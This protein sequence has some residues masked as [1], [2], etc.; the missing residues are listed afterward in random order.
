MEYVVSMQLRMITIQIN[1]YISF[2]TD[3]VDK[4]RTFDY[5]NQTRKELLAK[6]SKEFGSTAVAH[7]L[8]SNLDFDEDSNVIG[9]RSN[10]QTIIDNVTHV[11]DFINTG[12]Y[13]GPFTAIVAGDKRWFYAEDFR[14]SFPFA[15]DDDVIAVEG[16]GHWVHVDKPHE[17]IE[18]ISKFIDKVDS[19]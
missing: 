1:K 6:M 10:M 11:F 17:T 19:S 15:T 14:S 4:L 9:W 7:L 12:Q 8:L 18:L 2:V 3:V 16:A 13:H 5:R